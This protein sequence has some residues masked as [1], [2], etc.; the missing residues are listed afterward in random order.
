V[1]GSAAT[2]DEV[3]QAVLAHRERAVRVARSRCASPQDVDDVVQEAM[4]RV[5]AM[6]KV[7]LPRVGPLLTTVVANLIADSWRSA[8]SAARAQERLVGWQG[9]QPGPDEAVC[10]ELAA[11]WLWSRRAVLSE[12]DRRVLELRVEGL[13]PA[14]VAQR[15]GLTLKGVEASFTRARSG[16]RK[17]WRAA[18]AVAG[19]LWCQLPRP[20]EST[21]VVAL[22]AAA[23][24]G[25]WPCSPRPTGCSPRRR[26]R[27]RHR[28][29]QHSPREHRRRPGSASTAGRRRASPPPPQPRPGASLRPPPPPRTRLPS[30]RSRAA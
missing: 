7:D 11:R 12:Q 13:A 25:W 14:D 26:R 5:A 30:W 24:T 10:D 28:C 18:A 20:S 8:S 6:P 29:T 16:M 15:L 22:T 1:T 9:A 3:W 2:R 21:A 17:A 19:G 23:A 27:G 4:L